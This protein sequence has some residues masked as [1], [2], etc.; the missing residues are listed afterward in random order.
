[1]NIVGRM[2]LVGL[3]RALYRCDEEER[4]DGKGLGVY[5]IPNFGPLVYCG[6]Q[7]FISLLSTIRSSNDLGHPMCTNLREGDWM[8]DYIWQ[9]LKVDAGTLELGQWLENNLKYLKEIPRYLIPCYFDVIVT[10]TYLLLIE[11]CYN[12]MGEYVLYIFYNSYTCIYLLF[13]LLCSRFVRQGSGFVRS[14][15]LGSVQCGAVIKSANLPTFSPNLQAPLPPK[16]K[17]EHGEVEQTCLTLSAGLPHFAVGYMRS[18]GRDTFIALRG[19]FILTGRHSEARFHI[20]GYAACLRHGLIPNLL[21]G[22]K[23]ARFNCRDAIWWWLYC[24]QS[25]VKEVPEGIQIL[26]DKVS[27]LYPADDSAPTEAGTNVKY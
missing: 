6:L 5:N 21:D 19:M 3:N 4:D 13:N 18:W 17:N 15:A 7:G 26:T 12:L 9:R 11:H 16:R 20:L 27:R 2:D 14:L 24:I 23:N 8:L 22:G 10:G 1:M 25:Y